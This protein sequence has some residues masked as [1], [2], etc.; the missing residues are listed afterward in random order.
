[1]K[2]SRP[3]FIVFNIQQ[4]QQQQQQVQNCPPHDLTVNQQQI[5]IQ[6]ESVHFIALKP[7]YLGFNSHRLI[8]DECTRRQ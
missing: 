6:L 1:M 8:P 2:G 5:T 7:K 4:H 3:K